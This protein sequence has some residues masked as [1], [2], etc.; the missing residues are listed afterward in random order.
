MQ[1]RRGRQ[2]HQWWAC[3]PLVLHRQAGRSMTTPSPGM[4]GN[5][6]MSSNT[7]PPPRDFNTNIFLVIIVYKHGIYLNYLVLGGHTVGS[8]F[9]KTVHNAISI[10]LYLE[11]M[12]SRADLSTSC[13]T[14]VLDDRS[15]SPQAT[16]C[17]LTNVLH[18][19][20]FPVCTYTIII[21]YI[22]TLYMCLLTVKL[23]TTCYPE[24]Q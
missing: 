15:R 16:R 2:F 17:L 4:M 10:I 18:C 22:C 7:M 12:S 23:P 3:C 20:A 21:L 14:C 6:P 8:T 24:L 1:G 11:S 13:G 5:K 19:L 9:S